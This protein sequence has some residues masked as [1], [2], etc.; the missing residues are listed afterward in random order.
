MK[1]K[2]IAI[3]IIFTILFSTIINASG[4]SS[5]FWLPDKPLILARGEIRIVN[6]NIQ[7]MVG[8]GDLTFKA[9]LIEG[10]EIVELEKDLF[11]V[12]AQTYDTMA[13]LKI[14]IPK[15]TIPGETTRVTVEFKTVSPG[16][17]GGVSLGT[18][19]TISF[20]VI[21][22][23]EIAETKIPWITLGI[24]MGIL[25]ILIIIILITRKRNQK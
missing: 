22:S 17:T 13:P 6:L 14:K 2:K 5:P 16:K 3:S 9:E 23:E 7:N 10:H 25:I 12:K 8:E 19:M 21:V 11:E 20:D 24:I 4:V 18:G 15:E 1:T